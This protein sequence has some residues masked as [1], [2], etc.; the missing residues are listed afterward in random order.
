MGSLLAGHADP[1]IIARQGG[2]VLFRD[3]NHVAAEPSYLGGLAFMIAVARL[4]VFLLRCAR[5]C[6]LVA[7]RESIASD[8]LFRLNIAVAIALLAVAISLTGC[9]C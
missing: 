1:C 3:R 4:M 5:S 8:E 2:F 9:D 6:L 7:P